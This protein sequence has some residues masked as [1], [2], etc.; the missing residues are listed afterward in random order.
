MDFSWINTHI[1]DDTAKLRLKYGRERADEIL[2]IEC[3]RKH[4]SK[5]AETLAAN[6]EF[7]FPTA[8]SGEQSTSDRLARFHAALVGHAARVADLTAGLGI[9]AMAMASKAGN[10]VAVERDADVAGA[11]R[12]NSSSLGNLEVVCADCR[13]VIE[14]WARD[15]ISFDCILID[16]AR[17][18]ADGGRVYALDQC[19][20]DVVAMLPTL[21]RITRR[22][23]IKAS[24]MLDI[25]HTL[26]LLPDAA[27][28]IVLGTP[29]ECKE[30]DIVCD[31]A[32]PTE[33][34][35][36]RA[37]TLGSSF[38]SVFEFTRPQ[39][40]AAS[41]TT[42]TP[43]AGDY[44]FDPYPA[45]MKA[46]P[47]KILGERFGLKKLAPN[48]HLWTS[49]EAVGGFPGRTFMVV[50]ALPYMSKHI[51]RYASRY[52]KVSVTARNFDMSSDAL[53]AKLRVADGP[54][55]L[56]AVSTPTQKLLLTCE[57]V[58]D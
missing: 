56:F 10:V 42:A 28:V 26:G 18:A 12:S 15:G 21:K 57:E 40:T 33:S 16:P 50:E 23:V 1:N 36:I 11:L 24:P 35:L 4:G 54:L 39:D 48:T 20:P 25:T 6:P 49:A 13:D 34:P 30:L 3:R 52:P 44:V 58:N 5:L 55:R 27:E 7:V 2:Q 8:L 37:V 22:L 43:K 14:A 19:E 46:A 32:H 9:D 53:R 31:F 17:R 38:E 29:T 51:K 41:V 47:L 45:V